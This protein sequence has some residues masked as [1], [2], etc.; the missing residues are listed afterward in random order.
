MVTFVMSMNTPVIINLFENDAL[1]TKT[2]FD[3][4]LGEYGGL[5]GCLSWPYKSHD[6]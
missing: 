2:N 1:K 6:H 5:M 4:L 3:N